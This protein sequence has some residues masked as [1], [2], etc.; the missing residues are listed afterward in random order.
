VLQQERLADRVATQNYEGS[1]LDA[2]VA[3]E[4]FVAQQAVGDQPC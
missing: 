3:E 4:R 1:R 2:K